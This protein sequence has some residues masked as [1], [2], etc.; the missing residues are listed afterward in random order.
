[1]ISHQGQTE[2]DHL[3]KSLSCGKSKTIP[4]HEWMVWT[5]FRDAPKM[6]I[7]CS[8]IG[9]DIDHLWQCVSPSKKCTKPAF[10]VCEGKTNADEAKHVCTLMSLKCK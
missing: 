5:R 8:D 10:V 9:K 7:Q 6:M 4:Q 2:A 3:C 1:M